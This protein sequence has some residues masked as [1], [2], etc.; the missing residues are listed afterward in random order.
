MLSLEPDTIEVIKIALAYTAILATAA[1]AIATGIFLHEINRG[2]AAAAL[3]RHTQEVG[4]DLEHID[5]ALNDNIY[6][7]P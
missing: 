2:K 4:A 1:A 7:H 6:T 5:I 3:V